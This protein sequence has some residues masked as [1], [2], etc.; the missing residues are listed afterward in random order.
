M[1]G[2]LLIRKW[3]LVFRLFTLSFGLLILTNLSLAQASTPGRAWSPVD[4][5]VSSQAPQLWSPRFE[6]N[7]DGIP[8]LFGGAGGGGVHDVVGFEWDG[9]N[10]VQRWLVG[11]GLNFSWPV[12]APP[13]EFYVVGQ[14]P[15][16]ESDEKAWMWLA[17]RTGDSFEIE[18]VARA[19]EYTTDYSAAVSN[20]RRWLF[21]NDYFNGL[22]VL[23]SDQVN[24]WTEVSLGKFGGRGVGMAPLDDTTA[25][26]AWGNTAEGLQWATLRGD[27][28]TFGSELIG[29]GSAG[30]PT[31]RRRPNGGY[32]LGH[33]TKLPYVQIRSFQDGI[34]GV[35][36]TVTA[37]Y[38][39]PVR[40][41]MRYSEAFE[42]SRDEGE[43][44]AVAWGAFD[45]SRGVRAICVST[46]TDGGWTV[47]EQLENDEEGILPTVARDVNG[48]VWVAFWRYWTNGIFWAHTF[49]Q[50]TCSTPLVMGQSSQLLVTWTLSELAPETW[51]A[52]LRGPTGGP[53]EEVVRVRAGNSVQ[54]S[55]L[56]EAPV[57]GT[58]YRIRRECVDT[59]Y[60]WLSEESDAPVP[61]LVS[62]AEV[63]SQPGEVRLSWFSASEI[64]ATR[65]ERRAEAGLWMPLGEPQSVGNGL[66]TY[67][68]SGVASG[69]YA[70]RLG[71]WEGA[72]EQLTEETWVTV[73]SGAMLSLAGFQPN[74][75]QG[76][77]VISFSLAG[78]E[79]ATLDVVDV[80]GRVLLQ[81]SVGS[82]GPGSHTVRFTAQAGLRPGVYWVRLKQGTDTL[83][84]RGVVL[85]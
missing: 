8:F 42:M 82:L 69:R 53:F 61:T 3:V 31:F 80:R 45:G 40:P 25:V 76:R 74:P 16:G 46:P 30:N 33:F 70:Y 17:R 59:Y 73:P 12:L 68:D 62:L 85:P 11:R 18:N 2:H 21:F 15:F 84:K 41:E 36:E 65:V 54:M 26:L 10:W 35:P 51:W 19:P 78:A 20:Q 37:L 43:Y 4:T 81:R 5:L 39:S 9:E 48:D 77:V 38:R 72:S 22:R 29:N 13:G 60:Q 67:V 50:A 56:D 47:G 75:A 57:V 79:P 58:R 7:S 32:W 23:Y 24:E 66:L 83:T 14:D 64:G 6:I 28:L 49:T 52:V 27:E 1:W 34:W 44:P 55:W 63:E 71:Y